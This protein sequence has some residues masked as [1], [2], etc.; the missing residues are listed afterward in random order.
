[1]S[2]NYDE[3]LLSIINEDNIDAIIEW[4]TDYLQALGAS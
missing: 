3:I 4:L 1:M 2:N